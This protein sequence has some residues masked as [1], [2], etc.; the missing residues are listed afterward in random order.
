M[1]ENSYYTLSVEEVLKKFETSFAALSSSEVSERSSKYGKNLLPSRRRLTLFRII[2]NQFL[3][4]LIYILVAA[5]LVDIFG[6]S[7]SSN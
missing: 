2:L 6:Q 3:S 5:A 7:S 1:K 4:P